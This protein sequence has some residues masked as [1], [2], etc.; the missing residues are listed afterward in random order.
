[1]NL[2]A[3]L[4]KTVIKKGAP[5][6]G[7][8]IGGP[9]GAMVGGLIAKVFGGDPTDPKDLQNRIESDNDAMLKL[10]QIESDNEIRLAE[11]TLKNTISAR[12]R[13][14]SIT[15]ATGKLNWPMYVLAGVI[16]VGFFAVMGLLFKFTIPPGSKEIALIM[17]G[18]LGAKFGDVCNFFF[19]SSKSSSDKTQLMAG[20]NINE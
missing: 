13:E 9:G 3:E 1:M 2:W 7:G 14:V 18:V 20:K 12:D 15:K 6:L 5:L 4:G 10:A 17:F 11:I 19:G 16:V 8:V